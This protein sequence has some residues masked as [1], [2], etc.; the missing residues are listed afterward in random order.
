MTT[1]EGKGAGVHTAKSMEKDNEF[2]KGTGSLTNIFS[3]DA[4]NNAHAAT[5]KSDPSLTRLE[6]EERDFNKISL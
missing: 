5:A 3:P 6:K 2:D 1:E 4:A